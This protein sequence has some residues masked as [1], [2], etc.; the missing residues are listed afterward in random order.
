MFLAG[1]QLSCLGLKTEL[2]SVD[3]RRSGKLFGVETLAAAG[4]EG[5]IGCRPIPADKSL[6]ELLHGLPGPGLGVQRGRWATPGRTQQKGP[7]DK[8]LA[9]PH[10]ISFDAQLG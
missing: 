6:V 5:G 1:P 3:L 10:R 9:P 4:V 7:Q 8:Q 2:V